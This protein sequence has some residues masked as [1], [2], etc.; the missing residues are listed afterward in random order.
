MKSIDLLISLVCCKSKSH[1]IVKIP[2]KSPT[3]STQSHQARFDSKRA[4]QLFLS[5]TL[6]LLNRQ[7]KFL[8]QLFVG[9]VWRKVQAVETGVAT[10]Q[11]VLS[12]SLLNAEQLTPVTPYN[13]R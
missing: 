6:R 11:P 1:M 10:W 3:P 4:P 9:R 8:L 5:K 13:E 7:E 2:Y 12:A